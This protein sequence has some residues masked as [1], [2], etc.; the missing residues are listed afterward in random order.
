MRT[1]SFF[2]LAAL[3]AATLG[4]TAP[5]APAQGALVVRIVDVGAGLCTITE[6]PGAD[7]QHY[8]VFDAGEEFPFSAHRCLA[9]VQDMVE[10]DATCR[11]STTRALL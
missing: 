10:G 3:A 9:A 7:G 11:L 5:G 8:M 2:A 4:V 6:A 1:R